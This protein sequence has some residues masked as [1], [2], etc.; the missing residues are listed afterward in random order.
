M[1]TA[2]NM[3]LPSVYAGNL[4]VNEDGANHITHTV[5][6]KEVMALSACT[7]IA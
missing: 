3:G 6:L 4:L 2:Q 5:L 7:V 1:I